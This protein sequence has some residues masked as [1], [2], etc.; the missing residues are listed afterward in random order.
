ME[1]DG[2]RRLPPRPRLLTQDLAFPVQYRLGSSKN[3]RLLAHT[4]RSLHGY[5][6]S[7]S[8]DEVLS[9]TVATQLG[10]LFTHFTPARRQ[11]LISAP[12]RNIPI[13]MPALFTQAYGLEKVLAG[14]PRVCFSNRGRNIY[15]EAGSALTKSKRTSHLWDS[16]GAGGF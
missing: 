11:I 14:T 1:D 10:W 13:I 8:S 16:Y 4:L 12:V 6:S 15:W 5:P 7:H 2:C 9:S 3:T